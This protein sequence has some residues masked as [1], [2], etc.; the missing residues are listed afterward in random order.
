M[1]IGMKG[2]VWF[3][4]YSATLVAVSA[5]LTYGW[6]RVQELP[7]TVPWA[8]GYDMKRFLYRPKG[9]D[10]TVEVSLLAGEG[11]DVLQRYV[12]VYG[13]E[14]EDYLSYHMAADGVRAV[15]FGAPSTY[16][17]RLE[18]D[19]S[20][21]DRKEM[22]VFTKREPEGTISYIDTGMDGLLD[23][24]R[25]GGETFLRDEAGWRRGEGGEEVGG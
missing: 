25:R 3:M 14:L 20:G 18:G 5:G 6:I 19:R 10:M 1:R 22:V 13:G 17:V 15:M 2:R 24:M 16:C 23:I 4:V 11:G 9:A 12:S 21:R 8:P 7:G